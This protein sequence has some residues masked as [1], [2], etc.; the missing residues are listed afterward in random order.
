MPWSALPTELALDILA[1]RADAIRRE[2]AAQRAQAT[3][4]G[5][6]VRVLL[7]RYRMLRYLAE[8]RRYNPDVRAFVHRARL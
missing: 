1:R 3:W 4:R 6:R 7:G 8:F 2:R 5:Y